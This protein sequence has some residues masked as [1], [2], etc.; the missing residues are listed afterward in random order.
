MLFVCRKPTREHAL[1]RCA[2]F[3]LY[4]RTAN[5]LQLIAQQPITIQ[6]AHVLNTAQALP[7]L[8]TGR[9]TDASYFK[10]D[11][12]WPVTMCESNFAQNIE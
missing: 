7:I 2:F 9:H 4:R 8:Q 10:I 12:A 3:N 1:K 5:Y 6:Q 11:S